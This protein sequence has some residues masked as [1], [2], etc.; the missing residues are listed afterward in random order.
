[1]NSAPHPD[2]CAEELAKLLD[3]QS[4]ICEQI[5]EL[6]K[7]QQALVDDR[8]ESELL[9]LLTE[10]QQLIASHQALSTKAQPFRDQWENSARDSA[11]P[12]A[13]ARVEASWNRLR[14]ILN[15]IV[16]LEDASRA[17]LQEHHGEVSLDI[18]K[19]QRGRIANKAYGGAMRPPPAARYSD[20]QG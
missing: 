9:V 20:R 15:E 3:S 13:H 2:K 6:A 10:K 7:K 4:R 19:L 16:T 17:K 1:M 12:E 14:E 11:G 5:L 8:N 18:S